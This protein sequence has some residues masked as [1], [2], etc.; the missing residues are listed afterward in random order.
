MAHKVK[1]LKCGEYFDADKISY[2]KIGR[3]YAHSECVQ[4]ELSSLTKEQEDK[5]KF[6]DLVKSIYGKNYNY[7]L[8]NTQAERMIKE[9]GYT[10]SGMTGCLHWFYN[11]HHK[12]LEEGNGGIGIIPYIYDQVRDYYTQIYQTQEKNKNKTLKRPIIEFNIRPPQPK[13]YSP[14]L[15]KLD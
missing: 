15:L 2:T 13:E 11:L 9:Y 14:I 3:R 4:N 10:W 1:C 6:Y 12:S 7:I 5:A 8:I